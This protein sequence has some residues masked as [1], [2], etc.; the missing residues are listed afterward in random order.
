LAATAL[1]SNQIIFGFV[2][3]KVARGNI[4]GFE[5]RYDKTTFW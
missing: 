1:T 5:I 2:G 4:S 3:C